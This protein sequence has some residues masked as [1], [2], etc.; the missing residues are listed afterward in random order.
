MRNREPI[1]AILTERLWFPD[2]RRALKGDADGLLALFGDLSVER[3]L[4][5][6]RSGIFPWSVDPITW[7]SPDPRG[8]FEMTRFHTPR[9][10]ARTLRRNVFEVTRDKAFRQVMRG[11]ANRHRSGTWIGPDLIEAYVRMH[12]AGHAH[13]VECW[14]DGELVGGVYGVTVGGLFA[15]E[16]M[17][18]SVN[19]AS[20]VALHHLVHHLLQRE[21]ALFDIQMVTPVTRQLGAV[22]ISREEY[23]KRL[24]AAVKLPCVF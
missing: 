21:F 8:I 6:Y 10:L 17:F 1:P 24:A 19:D 11:C 4:L 2:P 5:A 9:S 18:H 20:K 13:S 23:L 3:L 14:R 16:S 15:G 7:W 12:E 22:E